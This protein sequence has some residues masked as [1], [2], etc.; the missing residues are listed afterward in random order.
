[1]SLIDTLA[2]IILA[3]VFGL[4][5][6]I[7]V[8]SFAY[9]VIA[10]ARTKLLAEKRHALLERQAYRFI[11]TVFIESNSVSSEVSLSPELS[12]ELFKLHNQIDQNK[13]LVR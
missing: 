6:L 13:E 4:V 8:G 1:M 10:A 2:P 7:V 12:D 9:R 3:V 5:F 11:E